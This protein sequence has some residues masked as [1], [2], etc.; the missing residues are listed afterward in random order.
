MTSD[1]QHPELH[2]SKTDERMVATL[3]AASSDLTLVL[4]GDDIIKDLS[5]SLEDP[6]S[7]V[8]PRWR[9]QPVE[10]VVH[11]SS[12]PLLRKMLR[13]ARGGKP[14]R[15]FD[16]SH[17]IEGGPHLPVQ[18]SALRIGSDDRIVLLGRDLRPVADLQSRLLSNR[19]SLEQNATRQR[20]AEAHYRL[21]FET[22]SDA[23]IIVDPANGRI[24]DANLRA[25][26]MFDTSA[27]ELTGKRLVGIFDKSRHADVQAMLSG[28]LATGAQQRLTIETPRS[29]QQVLID[30][31]LFRAG[32]LKLVLLRLSTSE[33]DDRSGSAPET[34]LG[35]L[36]RGAAEA[37]LLTDDDGRVLWA[38][39]SFIAMAQ[40]PLAAQALGRSLDDFFQ[41]GGLELDVLLA[42]VRRHG[43]VPLFAGVLRGALG[44]TADVDLSAIAM[45]DGSPARFG[46]VMR[47]GSADESRSGHG[48]SDLTRTAENLIEMI[49]RVPLKDLVRDTTDVIE[50]M[51]I[52]AALKLTGNNRASTARVLGLS[53]QALYLKL[54]RYGITDEE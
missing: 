23:L 43:R 36:V 8:I 18:Y 9:G 30:A 54:H 28:V 47:P 14:A 32:D 46:F 7:G 31:D 50:R 40:I 10:E 24:R 15:R 48:G 49:G 12:R 34:S 52:E 41:W 29:E 1:F 4:G 26:G 22:T 38:N 13:S 20:Q 2:L 39:D 6:L 25:C 45:P 37:V 19:Q 16:I 42:N 33:P 35:S 53:R 51:C 3:I 27:S 44:Q 5:F 21:L 11:G 17:P